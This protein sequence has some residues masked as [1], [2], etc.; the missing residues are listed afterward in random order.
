MSTDVVK[1]NRDGR[2]KGQGPAP[3]LPSV[4]ECGPRAPGRSET[5]RAGRG[6]HLNDRG[7]GI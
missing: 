3:E 4:S 7:P 2:G 1:W 6:S 5:L